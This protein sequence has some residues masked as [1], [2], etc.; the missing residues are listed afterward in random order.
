QG[1]S[2]LHTLRLAD[3]SANFNVIV[4]NLEKSNGLTADVLEAAKL[5]PAFWEQAETAFI[6]S[7]GADAK[8]VSKEMKQ[9]GTQEAL[10]M[11]VTADRNGK[12][13]LFTV[14]ILT[15]GVFSINVIYTN[16]TPQASESL[17]DNFFKSLTIKE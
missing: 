11:V 5:E 7:L 8:L 10:S 15:E 12:K 14:Y 2:T 16:R 4:T 13:S 17:R 3:S 6:A 9:V 1:V